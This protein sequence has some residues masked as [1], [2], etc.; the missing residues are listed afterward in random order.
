MH[1]HGT[2]AEI[3]RK[4]ESNPEGRDPGLLSGCIDTHYFGLGYLF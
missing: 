1:W 4:E 2:K 3:G